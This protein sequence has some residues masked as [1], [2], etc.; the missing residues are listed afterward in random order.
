MYSVLMCSLWSRAGPCSEQ[1]L[2]DFIVENRGIVPR[3]EYGKVGH[4]IHTTQKNISQVRTHPCPHLTARSPKPRNGWRYPLFVSLLA[5]VTVLR[6]LHSSAGL[7]T[8][9]PR[10]LDE[11]LAGGHR[12]RPRR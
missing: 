11:Y 2:S 4:S 5:A 10:D 3:M 1:V 7:L 12:T 8:V 9:G 6:H